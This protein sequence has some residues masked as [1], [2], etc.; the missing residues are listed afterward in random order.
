MFS[1][2]LMHSQV[3]AKDN[4]RLQS[5]S[6][7]AKGWSIAVIGHGQAV[8][9]PIWAVKDLDPS[10]KCTTSVRVPPT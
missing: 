1:H 5:R 9:A 6:Q 7:D 8:K 3:K 2:G 4:L 10:Q